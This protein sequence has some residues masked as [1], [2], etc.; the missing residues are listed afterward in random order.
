ME[1]FKGS[2]AFEWDKGNEKKNFLKHH[3]TNEE[4]EEVF[5]DP[6]KRIV[7]HVLYMGKEERFLLIGKTRRERILFVVF[8]IRGRKIRV[9]SARDLNRKERQ[10]YED[11]QGIEYP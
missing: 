11:S 10:L 5:F 4:C 7:Q 1:I 8:T 2:V 9:I 3:V 6:H